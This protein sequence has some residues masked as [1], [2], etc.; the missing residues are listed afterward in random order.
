M[1]GRGKPLSIVVIGA[2]GD[3]ARHKVIPALFTLY[4][5]KLLPARFQVIGFARSDFTNETFRAALAETVTCRHTPRRDC[6]KFT[7]DFLS[8]CFYCRGEY[9][10]IDAFL[11]LYG[12]LRDLEGGA[13]G[14]RLFYMAVPPSLFVEVA[15]A[16]G[17]AGLVH[18]GGPDWSR[19]VI[20]KPFGS[21]RS[22][23]D[24]LVHAMRQVFTE[25]QTFRIDHY[26]GKEVI[27]NLLVLRFA[28]AVFEPL[29]NRR[30]IAGV[31][32]IWQ[33]ADGVG[34]RGGYF[35][36]YGIVRDV[37]QNHLLQML[38]LTAMEPPTA[39]DEPEAVRASKV[40]LLR[41]VARV[42]RLDMVLG[43]YR[44]ARVEGKMRPDYRAE[45]HVP[46]DSR[47]PT[48]AAL[49]LRVENPRWQGVPFLI[50]AG[51]ALARR[52]TEIRL[53]FHPV[54]GN[55]FG[56]LP[57][58]RRANMLVLRVQP[59]E[60][61]YL[62][63]VNKLPGL[64][65]EMV[66]TPLDLRYAAAF[67]RKTIPSAYECLLWEA[68]QGDHGLFISED[69]LAAAWDVF[70]PVL[71]EIDRGKHEPEPYEWGGPGPA[72]ARRLAEDCGV[73]RE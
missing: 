65:M 9:A 67:R 4:C 7:D 64:A 2:S 26:L 37:V 1:K 56:N 72:A 20:E 39:L 45:P 68:L 31:E 66:E 38:A 52:T 34:L 61:I 30:H 60:A 58:P 40:R 70:T 21:D 18:C 11:D 50:R 23:S 49:R 46:K 63:V 54:P 47:T 27:Q 41:S 10:S 25:E 24:R 57:A 12:L 19:V 13:G 14:D 51:K 17:G 15:Q 5:R 16:I 48:Y 36:Q 55:I 32:I 59:D 29:W 3:L 44:R 28:N 43:Q 42:R 22:S 73:F 6:R 62:R 33:E 8:R 69:E 71:H 53:H 35:D